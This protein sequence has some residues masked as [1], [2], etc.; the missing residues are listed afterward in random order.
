MLSWLG[1]KKPSLNGVVPKLPVPD[2]DDDRWECVGHVKY[3]NLYPMKSCRA[4]RLQSAKV[5]MSISRLDI[6]HSNGNY[7]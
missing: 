4:N 3:L 5:L 2:K 1:L 7:V 6:M